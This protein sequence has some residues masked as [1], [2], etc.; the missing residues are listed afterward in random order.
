MRKIFIVDDNAADVFVIREALKSLAAEIH[1]VEDGQKAIQFFDQAD[2]SCPDLVLL[3]LN[4]P[5]HDGADILK[6]IR[7]GRCADTIV[8]V[9]TSSAS[10]RDLQEM[11]EL[12]ATTIFK[13]PLHLSDFMKLGDFVRDL[14]A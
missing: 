9:V 6:R 10:P 13:K 5:L 11:R 8:V 1:V 2:G 14:L 12:G 7:N 3:D 4:L